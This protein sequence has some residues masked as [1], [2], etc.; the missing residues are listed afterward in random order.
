MKSIY[1][2]V[3][4]PA[5][6]EEKN[7]Q[8]GVLDQVYEYLQ[9]QNYTWEIL[10]V[11]DG[12][13][14]KTAELAKEYAKNHKGFVVYEEPHRGK[15]GTVI[16]GMLHAKGEIVLFTD[17]DQATPI[18]EIEK[19]LPK[20]ENGKDIV[21]GSRS[22][23]EGAP[24]IRKLMAFGFS[25]LRTIILR[26]PYKDT[27]CGFKAFTNIAAQ[28]IFKRM[29]IFSDKKRV[30]GAAV[31][32]GFDLEVLYIARKLGLKVAE[33]PVEWHHQGTVRV[34]PIKDSIAGLRDML[35]VR[36]NALQGKY[37]V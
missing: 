37:R 1:L 20:F 16:A 3:V 29:K 17:M 33:V 11:D 26:L 13:Q 28:K 2:S 36:I 27:Q 19:F 12:S 31:N 15:A 30:Q 24:L 8:S 5:Y 34:N 4:I 10:I 9:K 21:I 6:N 18:H 32:A 22:G 35:Q 23:R 14:D 25:V 7:L